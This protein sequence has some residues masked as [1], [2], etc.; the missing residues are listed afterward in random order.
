LGGAGP[1][2]NI[3]QSQLA[4]LGVDLAIPPVSDG[5]TDTGFD[6]AIVESGGE[7]TFVTVNGCES[8]MT[9]NHLRAL[10]VAGGDAV[11]LSG[12][13]LV[14]E[15]SASALAQWVPTLPDNIM[16][17]LDPGPLVGDIQSGIWQAVLDRL[18]ILTVNMREAKLLSGTSD[19]KTALCTISHWLGAS[20]RA[21]VR[22][23]AE[24]AWLLDDQEIPHNILSREAHVVDTT[25]AGDVHTAAL[26][27][28]LA[29]GISF[30]QAV[31]EANVYASLAVEKEG[32][33]ASSTRK[34]LQAALAMMN[35]DKATGG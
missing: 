10:P 2:G 6:V 11:Y 35:E 3:V 26:I 32:P 16:V 20:S 25:G 28:G 7:R 33:S 5:A 31:F 34:E 9:F 22:V 13:N 12:Y 18:D 17:I 4:A 24:G 15:P 8:Q 1:F 29:Q 30:E 27:A 19:P 23:G 14:T 21:L